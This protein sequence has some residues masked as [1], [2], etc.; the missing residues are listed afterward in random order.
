MSSTKGVVD[1]AVA[2]S[3]QLTGE[4]LATLGLFGIE[5]DVLKEHHFATLQL[6]SHCLGLAATEEFLGELHGT[7]HEGL[8]IF[9]H[10]LEGQLGLETTFL[11]TTEVGHNDDGGA[12]F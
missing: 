12:V 7:V 10:R 6:F 11:G 2:E 9:G 8:K 4:V 5:A 3:G 1:V